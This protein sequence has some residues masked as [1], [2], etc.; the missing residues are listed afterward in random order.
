MP[1]TDFLFQAMTDPGKHS[2]KKDDEDQQAYGMNLPAGSYGKNV[3]HKNQCRNQEQYGDKP[4]GGVSMVMFHGL[5]PPLFMDMADGWHQEF[6]NYKIK[7]S[8]GQTKKFIFSNFASIMRIDGWTRFY[9]A[10]HP[11]VE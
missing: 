6:I 9:L 8:R 7:L 10:N 11:R 3:K 2:P 4:V 5:W 1:V